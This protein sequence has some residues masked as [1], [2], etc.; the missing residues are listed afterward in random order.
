MPDLPFTFEKMRSE[1][2]PA[3]IDIEHRSFTLPW[4]ANTYRH[5][6]L[7]N[8]H[9][10]YFVL[11]YRT[12]PPSPRRFRWLGR[13]VRQAPAAPIIGYGGFWLITD[14]AHISTIAIDTGWR[15]RGLGEYL[16]ASM[17]ERAIALKAAFVTL[18]V[19]RGN[20]AAQNLYHKYGFDVTGLRLRYYQDNQEDALLMTLAGASTETY[21]ETLRRLTAS[22][23]ARLADDR[24]FE[25]AGHLARD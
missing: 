16:L 3:V 15:G 1:D 25:S 6:V 4:S 13:R 21:R 22:L 11:R 2:I 17:I 8:T 19:R 12:L 14:E 18:E 24:H 9:A 23:S 10:H 5:E 20:L 7:D